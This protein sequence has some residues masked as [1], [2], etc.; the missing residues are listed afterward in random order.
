MKQL[1]IGLDVHKKR[2]ETIQEQQLIHK[3]FT[4]EAD[5]DILI[6]YIQKHYL[7]HPVACCYEAGCCGYHI[8]HALAKAGWQLLVVN[9]GDIP[10]GNK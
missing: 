4:I 8:Y 2:A 6:A 7:K 3:R 5:A 10:R 9:P 1:F